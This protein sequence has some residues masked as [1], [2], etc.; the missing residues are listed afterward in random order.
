MKKTPSA[1]L[2]I[3]L[4]LAACLGVAQAGSWNKQRDYQTALRGF[5]DHSEPNAILQ[6]PQA[7]TEKPPAKATHRAS[8]TWQ[9]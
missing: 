1:T 7:G 3:L 5:T 2:S 8:A 4:F 9:D 6:R